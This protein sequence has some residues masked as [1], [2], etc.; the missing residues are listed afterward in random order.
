MSTMR[1]R[2]VGQEG[3]AGRG[4]ATSMPPRPGP[5]ALVV[6]LYSE[7]SRNCMTIRYIVKLWPAQQPTER[8][9]ASAAMQLCFTSGQHYC[10]EYHVRCVHLAAAITDRWAVD[11]PG[12]ELYSICCS[13]K[14]TGW[15]MSE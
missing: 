2:A 12:P 9:T 5:A 7:N 8:A 13:W 1:A 11:K 3:A 6:L 14:A 10:L 4:P 15:S